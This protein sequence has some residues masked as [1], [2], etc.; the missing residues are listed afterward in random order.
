ML[1]Q[2]NTLNYTRFIIIR[3]KFSHNIYIVSSLLAVNIL[4]IYLPSTPIPSISIIIVFKIG[5]IQSNKFGIASDLFF[6]GINT[7]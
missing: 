6:I 7:N 3:Q 1:N 4:P 2:K 5:I